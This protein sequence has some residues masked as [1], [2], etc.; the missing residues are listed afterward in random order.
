M[1]CIKCNKIQEEIFGSG[2]FCSRACSNSRTRTDE[3]KNKISN[4]VKESIISGKT[5]IP[6]R[7]GIKITK[8]RTPEHNAAFSKY[9]D[10]RGRLTE[11][12]KKARVKASVYA[13]RAR[14]KNAIPIDADLGLIRK[15]YEYAP[16]GYQVDHIIALAVGGQH[17][18]DNLQYLPVAEN[19]RK[20]KKNIYDVTK[21]LRWQNFCE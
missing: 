15:I 8:P 7:K 12:Q 13:Y 21:I 19:A 16:P 4:G 9:W 11:D 6:I 3:I 2:R 18:Q 1:I 17:H 14:K 5:K 10:E 20:G